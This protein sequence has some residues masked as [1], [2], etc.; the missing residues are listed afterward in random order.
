M[1]MEKL[2][3]VVEILEKKK[4][5]GFIV[6]DASNRK[7]L[8]NFTGS[9]GILLIT[10][11]GTVMITDYRYVEQAKGQTEGIEIILHSDHT[12]H[13]GSKS[14]IYK[15]VVEQIN[16]F[17]LEKVGFEQDSMIFG[18]YNIL[19]DQGNFELVP[20][21][22]VVEDIRMVKSESERKK[23]KTATEIADAA[24]LYILDV[25]K[26]G[27]KEIEVS[28]EIDAFIKKNGAHNTGFLPTVA[29]G[30]RGALAHG[31]ASDKVIEQGDM[32]VLDFGANYEGYWS[33][34][35]R[36]IAVGA[37]DPELEKMHGIVY[38]ALDKALDVLKPGAYDQEIDHVIKEHIR[39]H[40]Y[41]E[42]AGTGTGHGI[43]I[44]LHETPFLSTKK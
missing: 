11:Q 26:P 33:D 14:T 19:K 13:K 25:I 32:I 34:M 8:T 22:D 15:K 41:I 21:L 23:L 44:D 18:L 12:G 16:R 43:G 1:F 31:R 2:S 10:K 6:T 38:E 27:I 24:F 35:S 29:S 37:P 4:M 39:S 3:R 7:Y 42:H 28:N 36:S 5:D 9:N 20:T 17:K 40:G 30:W